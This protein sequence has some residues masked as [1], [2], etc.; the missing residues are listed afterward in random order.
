ML[1]AKAMGMVKDIWELRGII[2]NSVEM[3]S[4]HPQGDKAVWD[5]D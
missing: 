2:A 4:Y 5:K 3:V 1:Q